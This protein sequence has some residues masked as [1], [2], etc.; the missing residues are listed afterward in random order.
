MKTDGYCSF[1]VAKVMFWDFVNLHFP[2]CKSFFR[3]KQ[4]REVATI[5]LS[6]IARRAVSSAKIAVIVKS[7][8]VGSYKLDKELVPKR[9]TYY[10]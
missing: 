5:G 7:A 3:I 8:V 9:T 2:F 10:I 6:W 1:I 4:I